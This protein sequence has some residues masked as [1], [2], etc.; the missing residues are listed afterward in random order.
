M[1]IFLFLFSIS[2]TLGARFDEG[3]RL[4]NFYAKIN[5]EQKE[6]NSWPYRSLVILKIPHIYGMNAQPTKIDPFISILRC[7][8]HRASQYSSIVSHM[9]KSQFLL[10]NQPTVLPHHS[11]IS[12][13][14]HGKR[15]FIHPHRQVLQHRSISS[16]YHENRALFR[17]ALS[18]VAISFVWLR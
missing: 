1:A 17:L 11:K 7:C 18:S 14:H 8:G 10:P 6:L 9:F 12:P 4:V 2:Q 15:A 5:V 16:P 3:A 13:H